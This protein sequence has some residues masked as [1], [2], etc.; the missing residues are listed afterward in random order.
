MRPYRFIAGVL[1]AIF[2]LSLTAE[3]V[4]LDWYLRANCGAGGNG[5]VG[6]DLSLEVGQRASN[7]FE[8]GVGLGFFTSD[9]GKNY[10]GLFYGNLLNKVGDFYPP[11]VAVNTLGNHK[12][13]NALNARAFMGYDFWRFTGVAPILHISP[14]IGLGYTQ[15]LSSYSKWGVYQ[16]IISEDG[17]EVY[18][19]MGA[20]RMDW[21]AKSRVELDLGVR[22]EVD[23]PHKWGV[24]GFY[25]W[26]SVTQKMSV[27]GISV[28]KRF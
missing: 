25:R 1:L 5:K 22:V 27:G 12:L 8:Y 19:V 17:S 16:Q 9:F 18:N 10:S 3:A 26:Y 23:L 7:G 11:Y 2:G 28:T 6:I 4:E 14:V 20:T 13:T 21:Q 15:F 24:G